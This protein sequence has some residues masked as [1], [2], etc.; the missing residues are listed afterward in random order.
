MKFESIKSSKFE[1][2]KKNEMLN[3]IN[4]VG[5]TDYDTKKN[6]VAD[7][8]TDDTKKVRALDGFEFDYK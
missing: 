1:R 7:C 5:G 6:G 4:I 3:R 2:F 8:I